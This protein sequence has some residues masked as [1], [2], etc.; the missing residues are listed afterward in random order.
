MDTL[1]YQSATAL[2]K[3]L[4]FFSPAAILAQPFS[5]L[6][7]PGVFPFSG[8]ARASF[9]TGSAANARLLAGLD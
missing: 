2:K 9:D 5:D 1:Y 4:R 6:L 8:S 7:Y 3:D